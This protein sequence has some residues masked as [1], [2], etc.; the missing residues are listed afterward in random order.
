[1]DEPGG[2][3]AA[4]LVTVEVPEPG[5][6]QVRIRVR[7]ASVNPVDAF[8]RSAGGERPVWCRPATGW[9]PAGTSPARST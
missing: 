6:G 2:P 8:V 5:P 7:A 4:V 3:E 1:M 9:V